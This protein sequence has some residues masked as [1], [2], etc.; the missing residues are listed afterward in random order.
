[1]N[2]AITESFAL[3]CLLG[4]HDFSSDTFKIALYAHGAA[5]NRTTPAYTADQEI[6][7]TAYS[8]GGEIITI[9][10]GYPK[11][12]GRIAGVRFEEALWPGPATFNYQKA[13]IYNATKDNRSV[14]AVDFGGP[15]GPVNSSHRIRTLETDPPLLCLSFG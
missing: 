14:L 10:G 2:A 15:R 13:L 4:I 9:S 3:E 7:G 1:M 6:S 11:I 8:E 5:I 12:D